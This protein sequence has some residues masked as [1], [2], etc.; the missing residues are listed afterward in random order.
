M[1]IEI[2]VP[3]FLFTLGIVVS[4]TLAGLGIERIIQEE[5]KLQQ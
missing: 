1:P 3:I 2:L 5:K 4:V